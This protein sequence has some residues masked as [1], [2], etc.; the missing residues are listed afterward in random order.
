MYN[1]P[2]IHL[3]LDFLKQFSGILLNIIILKDKDYF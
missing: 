2:H 3:P 1:I